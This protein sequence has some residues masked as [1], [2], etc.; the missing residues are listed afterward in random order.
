MTLHGLG[1]GAFA[2]LAIA[3][4]SCGGDKAVPDL[5]SATNA[6]GVLTPVA[7]S[8]VVPV[9]VTPALGGGALLDA[10]RGGGYIIVFRHALTDQAQADDLGA[11]LLDIREGGDRTPK[12]DCALQRNLTAAGREQSRM[13]GREIERLGI[14]HTRALTS[15][16]CRTKETAG[17]A[18]GLYEINIDLTLIVGADTGDLIQTATRKLFSAKPPPGLNTIMITHVSNTLLVGLPT[19]AEGDSLVLQPN[20]SSW[21]VIAHVKAADWQDFR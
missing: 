12:D 4:L 6:P 3:V 8:T 19:I 10:L 1:S 13:I 21:T 17:F 15:P 18:F 7:R 2:W 9:T 5:V 20:G 11:I 14:P 16:Y